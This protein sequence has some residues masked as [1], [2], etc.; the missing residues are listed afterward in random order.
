MSTLAYSLRHKA[1]GLCR[2]CPLPV[3][4]GSTTYCNYHREKDR[5]RGRKTSRSAI[6]NLKQECLEYYGKECVCCAEK[7]VEFLTIDHKNGQGNIQ[8][9]KLFG[10]NVG[11][12]HM[13]RWLKKN[14]FPN[15]FQIL[16]MN[17]NW[18]T[19]YREQCPHQLE[20]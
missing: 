10:Y 11:G 3:V 12:L 4:V 13:Y 1:L 5:I 7:K 9:K 19:R 16:C 14:N 15:S 18:A 20:R 6:I 8:R 17:C 2:V